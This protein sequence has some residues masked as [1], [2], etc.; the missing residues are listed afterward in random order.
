MK[1]RLGAYFHFKKFRE[2]S[3]PKIFLGQDP[4]PEPDPDVFKSRI[5]IRSKIVR[6]RKNDSYIV[7]R[8][9]IA[10]RLWPNYVAPAPQHWVQ[11]YKIKISFDDIIGYRQCFGFTFIICGSR[12]RLVDECGSGSKSMLKNSKF[13]SM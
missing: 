10:L 12:S 6:I 5:R 4:D 11:V 8:S 9:R 7:S 3:L 2:K 1:I 13:F